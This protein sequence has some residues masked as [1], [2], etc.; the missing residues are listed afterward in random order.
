MKNWI[1]YVGPFSFP[2]GQ[3]GSR[4]VYGIARSF[5]ECGFDVVVGAGHLET[6]GRTVDPDCAAIIYENIGEQPCASATPAQKAYQILLNSGR[7]TVD[8]LDAMPSR[9]SFVVTYGAGAAFMHRVAGWC[10]RN[11]VPVIADVV[12]WYDGSH[13]RG[14]YFGPF[15]ISA[16]VAMHHYYRKCDGVIAISQYLADFYRRACPHVVRIP[17]T[18]DVSSVQLNS[19]PDRDVSCPLRLIYAGTPGR[20]D[21][22][23]VVINGISR[24][25]PTGQRVVLEVLGPTHQQVLNLL[26]SAQLPPFVM[27]AGMVPQASI[28]ESLQRA[29]F[30]VLLREPQRF[31]NAGFPT[32]FVESFANG[33]PVIANFTSDLS[34]YLRDGIEGIVCA[35]PSAN[36]FAEALQRAL[37]LTPNQLQFMRISARQQAEVSFDYRNYVSDLSEF[38]ASI[39]R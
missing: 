5:V 21:L 22:L 34:L 29:D 25:D 9:P 28:F 1:A 20:K 24:I 23:A 7:N 6:F 19:V 10:K 13:M 14:G 11:N 15:H 4:R 30:S 38:L 3:A 27:V 39:Q 26:G 35:S 2:W 37:A 18:L 31:A 32:K 12:E 17:P 33:V 16:K 36:D 8:W